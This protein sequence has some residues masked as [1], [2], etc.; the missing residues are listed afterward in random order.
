[1]KKSLVSGKL[2]GTKEVQVKKDLKILD[3]AKAINKG[4]I[5]R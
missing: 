5:I 2:T 3:N 4:K 1:M